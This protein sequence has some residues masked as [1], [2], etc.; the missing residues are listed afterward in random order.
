VSPTYLY[1]LTA[2]DAPDPPVA[3]VGL[4]GGAVRR[5]ASDGVDA[6]VGDVDARPVQATIERIRAH[7]SVVATALDTGSTPLPARFGQTF[8]SDDECLAMLSKKHSRMSAGL[9]QVAGMVEMTVILRVDLD[10][11]S[12][13]AYLQ[14][15]ARRQH[16]ARDVSSKL[17]GCIRQSAEKTNQEV[18][19]LS[20]LVDRA[21]VAEYLDRLKGLEVK[22]LGPGAP[23]SFG[24][25][26]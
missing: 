19:T 9:A 1:C 20:H 18:L 6:W 22:V 17:A 13:T 7:D 25:P 15:L 4:D 21:A 14:S 11:S 2:P 23:Y 10:T 24:P 16:A 12:G 5:L 26:E 8:G 3:T